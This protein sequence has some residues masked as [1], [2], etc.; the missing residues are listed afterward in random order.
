[1]YN[2]LNLNKKFNLIVIGTI[3]IFIDNAK[4]VKNITIYDKTIADN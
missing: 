3:F 4:D 2:V 1:M